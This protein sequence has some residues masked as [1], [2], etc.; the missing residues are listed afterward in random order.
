MLSKIV[1]FTLVFDFRLKKYGAGMVS[2]YD[3]RSSDHVLGFS[4]F[5]QE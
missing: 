5:T 1:A 3:Q 4:L 2:S